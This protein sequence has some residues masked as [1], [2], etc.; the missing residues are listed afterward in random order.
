MLSIGLVRD[1]P[2]RVINIEPH[3]VSADELDSWYKVVGTL[4]ITDMFDWSSTGL[5]TGD[6]VVNATTSTL[7]E[8]F[9]MWCPN[10]LRELA[11]AHEIR[12]R[13]RESK[14]ALLDIVNMHMCGPSCPTVLVI[15][16]ILQRI[17]E[18]N[19]IDIARVE[20]KDISTPC[21]Q[22][23][24]QVAN[25]KLIS[26]I[27]SEWQ[28]AMSTDKFRMYVCGPCGRRTLSTKI[29]PVHPSDFN[30]SLLRNDG[31]PRKLIP[32]MYNFAAYQEVLL[33]PK[34][35]TNRNQLAEILM[36]DVCR[37]ELV[38]KQRM[39]R[40]SLANWLYYAIE[41]LPT[42][43][44]GA[45][46]ASTFTEHLLLARARCS[47]ISYRFSELRKSGDERNDTDSESFQGTDTGSRSQRCIK[48][49]VLVMPQNSTD[50][51]N[52]LPPPPE[53]IRDTVCSVFVA[54][55]KPSKDTIG[56]LGPLL[57]RKSRL[58]KM[59]QFLIRDNPHYACDTDFH[60]FSQRNL[61]E[62]FGPGSEHQDEGVPCGLQVGFIE[63][64]NATRTSMTDYTERNIIDDVPETGDER[65]LMENVGYTM[66]DESPV[67]Y[68]DM[69]LKA[70]SHCLE[71]GRFVR[72]QGGDRFV[73][74]FENPS[75]LTW[76]FPH[77]DPWG[78]GGFHE[79]RRV[80]AVTMEEQLRYLLELDDSPF[81]RDPNFAFVYYNILQKKSICDSVRFRVKATEQTRIVDELL[82][83]DRPQLE[84]L[85]D[86]FK[87]DP[88]YEPESPQQ[89]NMLAL[90]NRIGTLLH[91]LPGTAGY[92]LKM[93]NEIRSL[94]N[95]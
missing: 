3:V 23:F 32:T 26:S 66:G 56:R 28:D 90:V 21:A 44:K 45:F 53:V 52:V 31:L 27:V 14:S 17:R 5:Q 35:L 22:P 73:P 47:R 76:L 51:V 92:K 59:I 19:K 54:K 88:K 77:L 84:Q 89:K 12:L 64:S 11:H 43:A 83:V 7:L 42:D 62:L 75:L 57:A 94:V 86:K 85:I 67:S 33:N 72:S 8:V 24:M 20:F 48:G 50:L 82:S 68:R 70:L 25:D 13:A 4:T 55:T 58:L 29:L 1:I 61:D 34:G 78:I 2:E 39:P 81:E 37:R 95:M 18:R 87:R 79:P 9:H 69:K 74:D 63:D 16:R 91:D 40:L 36:C 10:E 41:E 49:N 46:D 6:L 71:G 93:R 38:G 30:L 65:I 80:V 15:F 60:G